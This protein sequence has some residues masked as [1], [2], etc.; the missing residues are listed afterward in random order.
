MKI[1]TI[2]ELVNQ[3]FNVI[4]INAL[5]QFWHTTKSF[6]CI[7]SPK[8][9]NLFLF[10]NGCKITYTDKNNRTFVANS[11]DV[12]YTPIGSEYKVQLSDFDDSLSHTIGVNFLLFD[13][14]GE[15][16]ILSDNIQIFH[17]WENQALHMLFRKFLHYDASQ[18]FLKNRI[19][20][21][22]ILLLLSSS[23]TDENTPEYIT[24][25]L[26]YLSEHIKE[27]PTIASLSELSHISEVY[28]RKQ[29]KACMGVTPIEYRNLMRL[30]SAKTYLEYGEISVQEI[31]DMLGYSTVSHFIKEFK[32]RYGCPPMQYRKHVGT[33]GIVS[34]YKE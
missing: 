34:S 32:R 18:S 4:F 23:T 33:T 11:G 12:V 14:F 25:A 16:I 6:Q 31:S 13:D 8:K 24:R 22:E 27:K 28:F 9:Q 26:R 5:Q 30:E 21:M 19:L 1:C 10:L 29:F 15:D 2:N 20:L 7:G 17:D 3:N